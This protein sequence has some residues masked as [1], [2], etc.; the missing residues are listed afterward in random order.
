[1]SYQGKI[2]QYTCNQCSGIITTID[3]DHGTTPFYLNC[4][5]TP[6]CGGSMRSSMYLVDQTLKPDHEWYK[7]T[8][9]IRNRA[10]REHVRMGGL[11]IRP[12]SEI[13]GE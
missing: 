10:M 8:G 9:K 3:R 7:P 4:R 12:I 6:G 11:D 1:M 5:A 13:E 2:N